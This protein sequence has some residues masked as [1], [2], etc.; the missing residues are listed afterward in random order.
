[1]KKKEDVEE[2]GMLISS[3]SVAATTLSS[4]QS[5]IDIVISIMLLSLYL[6]IIKTAVDGK[7]LFERFSFSNK[8]VHT[9][10]F[11]INNFPFVWFS[12]N[13]KFYFKSNQAIKTLQFHIKLFDCFSLNLK[14]T[15]NRYIDLWLT[16]F[17]FVLGKCLMLITSFILRIS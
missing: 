12:L 1:M 11:I 17:D 14:L 16:D 15:I 7:K 3:A 13:L 8:L 9:F 4:I 6:I 10:I 2:V 5:T